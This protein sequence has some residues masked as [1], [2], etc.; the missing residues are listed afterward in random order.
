[1]FRV[2]LVC[3]SA[4]FAAAC[5]P[6]FAADPSM[7]VAPPACSPPAES[8]HSSIGGRRAAAHWR[9]SYGWSESHSLSG[10]GVGV[11]F[12]LT[13]GVGQLGA[14]G[15]GYYAVNGCWSNRPAYDRFGNYIGVRPVNICIELPPN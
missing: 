3:F 11:A 15:F 2:R 13:P 5:A 8:W 6:T 9:H 4:F 12:G 7:R 10:G 14:A 1:M